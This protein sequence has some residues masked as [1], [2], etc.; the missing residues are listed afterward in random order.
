[1]L[2]FRAGVVVGGA[3][4][5][6]CFVGHF[7]CGGGCAFFRGFRLRG[8]VAASFFFPLF[9]QGYCWLVKRLRRCVGVWSG[10]ISGAACRA[11]RVFVAGRFVALFFLVWF[12]L[13]LALWV[14]SFRVFTMRVQGCGCGCL[15]RS[16]ASC[17]RCGFCCLWVDGRLGVCSFFVRG[18]VVVAVFRLWLLCPG[19]RCWSFFSSRFSVFVLCGGCYGAFSSFAA[20]GGFWFFFGTGGAPWVRR[21]RVVVLWS[22]FSLSVNGV[23]SVVVSCPE[24]CRDGVVV[25]A[26]DSIV[27]SGS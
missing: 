21:S 23:S 3:V 6:R 26:C 5:V 11:F 8:P 27:L 14:R 22:G 25:R 20:C 4:R 1:M 13:L 18:G 16:V 12:G 24:R 10:F 2:P 15:A 17:C 7:F 9:A 19:D